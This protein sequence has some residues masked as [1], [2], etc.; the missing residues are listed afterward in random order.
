MWILERMHILEREGGS[1]EGCRFLE[2]MQN[3]GMG[4]RFRRGG[5][6]CLE[7]GRSL[8]NSHGPFSAAVPTVQV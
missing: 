6:D 1:G 8:Q 3:F 4:Y 7:Q 5:A 2:E